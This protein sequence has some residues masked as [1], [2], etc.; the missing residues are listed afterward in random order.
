MLMLQSAWY[1]LNQQNDFLL[2]LQK[3]HDSW[4]GLPLPSCAGAK[5]GPTF[6]GPEEALIAP[7]MKVQGRYSS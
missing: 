7:A 3:P 1:I 2:L 5:E 6:H 4:S